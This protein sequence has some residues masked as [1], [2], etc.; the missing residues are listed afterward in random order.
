MQSN[1]RPWT[2]VRPLEAP[3]HKCRDCLPYH[4]PMR[5]AG[6]RGNQALLVCTVLAGVPA[7]AAATTLAAYETSALLALTALAGFALAAAVALRPM[8]GVYA[9]LLAIPLEPMGVHLAGAAAISPAQGLLLLVAAAVAARYVIAGGVRVHPAHTAFAGL[10]LVVLLGVAFAP[11]AGLVLKIFLTWTAFGIVSLFVAMAD[12]REIERLLIC[13]VLAGGA[14]GA[15]AVLTSGGQE[16]VAGGQAAL[17]RAEG[18]FVHPAVLSSFLVLALPPA[19]ILMFR[20]PLPLR[21]LIAVAAGLNI[22]GVAL[23]LT[24][25]SILGAVAA[26]LVLLL[27]APFRRAA[28][29]LLLGF[30]L[31]IALNPEALSSSRQLDVIGTRLATITETG[32]TRDNQRV[33]IW[34]GGL[35]MVVDRPFLGVGA[36]QFRE[37]SPRYTPVGAD[38]T[39][40]RHAHNLPLTFTAELGLVGLALLAWFGIAV[41]RSGVRTWNLRDPLVS[42][43]ALGL[44]AGL[45]ALFVNG[46]TDYPPGTDVL[47]AVIL[48]EVGAVIALERAGRPEPGTA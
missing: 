34:R 6:L 31:F 32:P 5:E 20:G 38:G 43:L 23:S 10:L 44:V 1:I 17:G 33:R 30:V 11:D 36:G 7:L 39:A 25:G 42:P 28:V 15:V 40:Y 8:L 41:F 45:T 46:L 35:E 48:L 3:V 37:Y 27:W 26:L 16:L 9:A 47:M 13:L 2:D 4:V 29:A 24:R 12:R 14:L 21:V 18:S 22:A 19:F